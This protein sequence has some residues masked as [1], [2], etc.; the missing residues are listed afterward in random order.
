MKT[1]F[2]NETYKV[3][4]YPYGYTLKTD[5]YY[6]LEFKKGKGFRAVET[7]LNPKT[8]KMNAP[9]KTTYYTVA[10]LTVSDEGKVKMHTEDFYDDQGKDR[11]Y[12]FMKENFNKF[13]SE[14]MRWVASYN[15]TLLKTDIYAKATYC[16]SDIKK[17][18]PLYDVAI[19]ALSDIV[20]TGDNLWDQVQ[21]DWQ[22][23]E[24]L[25]IKGYNPFK[26]TTH[27]MVAL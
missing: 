22:A 15:I 20:K 2:T 19:K 12:L 16:G 1:L 18:L 7:T 27:T 4:N 8:Q 13:T 24:S 11:G 3:E 25:E 14:E 17:L 6:S 26:V 10:L 9:K 23:V 5:K 21:I